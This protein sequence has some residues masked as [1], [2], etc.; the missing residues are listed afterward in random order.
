MQLCNLATL[1]ATLTVRLLSHC[2]QGY[3]RRG[4]ARAQMKG[5]SW[6]GS[7]F[8]ANLHDALFR[9]GYFWVLAPQLMAND[10]LLA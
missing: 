1:D 10:V 5:V 4:L 9:D 2:P 7:G 8:Q 6:L 3:F